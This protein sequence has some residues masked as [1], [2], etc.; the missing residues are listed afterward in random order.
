MSRLKST[1]NRVWSIIIIIIC[2]YIVTVLRILTISRSIKCTMH[3]ISSNALLQMIKSKCNIWQHLIVI[4]DDVRWIKRC[5]LKIAHVLQWILFE[6]FFCIISI[7]SI[8]LS[9][10]IISDQQCF[11]RKCQFQTIVFAKIFLW[12]WIALTNFSTNRY[13]KKKQIVF[14]LNVA[15]RYV[16]WFDHQCFFVHVSYKV[17]LFKTSYEHQNDVNK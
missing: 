14:F 10:L 8:F 6:V 15:N 4:A 12:D 17:L 3:V 2:I 5:I 1:S 11:N 13:F 7:S 9:W 16:D